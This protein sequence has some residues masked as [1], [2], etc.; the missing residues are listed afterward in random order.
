M[1]NNLDLG[2]LVEDIDILLPWGAS[3]DEL[4]NIANPV[5]QESSDRLRLYWNDHIVF[6]GIRSQVEAV[7]YRNRADLLDHPNAN[8]KLNIVSLN[9]YPDSNL[10]PREQHELLKKD[11]IKAL[12]K[13]SFDDIGEAPF[14]GLPFTEWDLPDALVVLMVFERFGEYCLGEIW[15]KPLPDWRISESKKKKMV[16][17]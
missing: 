12:G 3:K 9:F 16:Q 14:F 10:K 5:L 11:F 7:F 8:D 17:E 15:H 6:G 2:I 4:R 13:P 1:V